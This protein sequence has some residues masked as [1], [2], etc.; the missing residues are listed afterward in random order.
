ML[1]YSEASPS[2]DEF[3]LFFE[4]PRP[5]GVPQGDDFWTF[6]GLF[7]GLDSEKRELNARRVDGD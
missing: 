4:N 5:F 7:R 2:V 3:C 1:R 6:D